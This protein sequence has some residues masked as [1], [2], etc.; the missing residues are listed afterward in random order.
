[1]SFLFGKA[2]DYN[3]FVKQVRGFTQGHPQVL[4][5]NDRLPQSGITFTGTGA[6]ELFV[7]T[8]SFTPAGNPG[9]P[10]GSPGPG[11]LYRLTCTVAGNEASSP[12]AEFDVEQVEGV[13]PGF[14]GILTVGVRFKPDGDMDQ[15]NSPQL[16][17][18]VVPS[19]L[20]PGL[21]HGLELILTTSIDWAVSDTIEFRLVDHFWGRDANDNFI[22]QRFREEAED[23]NLDFITEWICRVPTIA[24]AGGSPE[25]PFYT[26]LLSSFND[27]DSRYNVS[28]MAA[29]AFTSSAPFASH[30]GTSGVRHAFLQK[31][32]FNFW[33]TGDADGF[34]AVAR[35]GSVYE[36]ITAQFIEVFA[37]GNQHPL[38]IF[39]GAMSEV[40]TNNAS[41]TDNDEHAA[42]WD[43]GDDSTARFRWVD[44]TWLTVQ[45]RSV[46]YQKNR[47]D[48]VWIVPWSSQ[49]SISG[50]TDGI[51]SSNSI[52]FNRVSHQM[53]RRY[54]NSY[55]LDPATLLISVPQEAVVGDLKYVK[56]VTGNGLNAEDTTTDQSVSPSVDW[57]A[58][59]NAQL[60]D[61]DNFCVMELV[62]NEDL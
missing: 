17:S 41:Q 11:T 51:F 16:T 21:G 61:N 56:Y 10:A 2:F 8:E 26:G 47:S 44:G 58:F 46:T 7:S 12:L 13:S 60:A 20:S 57:I 29:T 1:M 53:I 42:W 30:T 39:V 5:S 3:D 27:T 25:T 22:E 37:T 48:T 55:E 18:P 4:K 52:D 9:S 6:G 23:V 62:A 59:Q 34:Y 24:N 28:I 38:P 33:L 15:I 45:N 32:P 36:H 54:D 31:N 35:P 43:P 19:P 49:P 14:L 40:N 50:H